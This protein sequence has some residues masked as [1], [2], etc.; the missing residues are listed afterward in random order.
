MKKS[1]TTT[2]PE[3]RV[4]LS[5][6]LAL[7]SGALLDNIGQHSVKQLALP[8]FN[9][10]LG[11]NP[12]LVGLALTIFR[13]WDAFT[14]P[15]MGAISDGTR[16]RHGR[17]RPWMLLGAFLTG[18][19]FPFLWF[20]SPEW[21]ANVI[22]GYFI[23]VGIVYFTAYTLFS[24]PY[25]A[26]AFEM[27]P[28]YDEKTRLMT[29]RTI[30]NGI[31]GI[32][33]GWLYAFSQSKIFSD[34][35][36]GVKWMGILVGLFLIVAGSIPALVIRERYLKQVLHQNTIG[37]WKGIGL[38]VTNRPFAILTVMA[39][40]ILVGGNAINS[41]GFYLNVYYVHHGDTGAASIIQGWAGTA[42]GIGTL[43]ILPFIAYVATHIGKSA[44][45]Y[46]ALAFNIAG[47]ISAWYLI[48]PASPWL[49]LIPFVMGVPGVMGFWLMFSSMS[50]DV[51]DH[52]EWK[53]GMRREGMF[54][55]VYAWISK[56]AV[57]LSYG[58]SGLVVLLSGFQQELG[59]M[60]SEATI[61]W[62]RVIYSFGPVGLYIL[63]GIL[64]AWYPLNRR[65]M[66]EIRAEL[67]ERRGRV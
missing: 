5:S 49:Q 19:I 55:A 3:D 52:D 12:A 21:S 9:I 54:S 20:V 67:E 2:R 25:H 28:D 16:S 53:T 10:G 56:V 1:A 58:L 51:C 38:T 15:T 31:G 44:T 50:A 40:L 11:I 8:V 48:T 34:P 4:P 47:S 39:M 33:T 24:V 59:A 18:A 26:L 63:A 66:E 17:R 7:G 32:L 35:L 37:F 13:L 65:R 62:M 45:M 14:D 6:K 36:E 46:L 60:Q 42:F 29:Y 22:L 57:S 43:I 23:V 27:T 61:H 30:F 64:L 41:L